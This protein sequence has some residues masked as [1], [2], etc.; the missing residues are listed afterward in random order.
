MLAVLERLEGFQV[1]A[2]V[3]DP[4]PLSDR[5]RRNR[6]PDDS[7]FDVTPSKEN[8]PP[9]MFSPSFKKRSSVSESIYST[10]IVSALRDSPERFKAN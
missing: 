4:S 8:S 2:L 10:R 6:S 1:S 5:L 3:P 7:V 9:R